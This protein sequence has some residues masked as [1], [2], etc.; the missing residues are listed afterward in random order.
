MH[1]Q[2]GFQR[3]DTLTGLLP[4]FEELEHVLAPAEP[5]T[6]FRWGPRLG[7]NAQGTDQC[8]PVPVDGGPAVIE[9]S[10]LLLQR[11]AGGSVLVELGQ[12]LRL[13]GDAVGLA[14]QAVGQ[15]I[16]AL[17]AVLVGRG[18]A[19][20]AARS[21]PSGALSSQAALINRQP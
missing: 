13:A 19:R 20:N 1:G 5:G 8:V 4:L 16:A 12:P 21:G 14:A 9:L 7:R 11:L 2:G 15:R 17:D 3:L 6:E 10:T 18:S